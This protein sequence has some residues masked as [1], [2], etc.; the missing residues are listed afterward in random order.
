MRL[1]T[2]EYQNKKGVKKLQVL[3][4]PDE[5]D[6]LG[7]EGHPY[8]D[9]KRMLL[10]VEGDE[11]GRVKKLVADLE[12]QKKESQPKTA[13]AFMTADEGNRDYFLA[14]LESMVDRRMNETHLR[15]M[16][17]LTRYEARDA[18]KLMLK[19]GWV[20]ANQKLTEHGLSEVRE[21]MDMRKVMYD[22]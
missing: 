12:K 3:G 19:D 14:W 8:K 9:G 17:G 15:T 4:T 22:G 13:R 10:R 18:Y 1:Y 11:I 21:C 7:L 2:H 16:G 6:Q 20:G 5:F